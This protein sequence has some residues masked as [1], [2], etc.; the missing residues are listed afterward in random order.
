MYLYLYI[1]TT[2]QVIFEEL[3]APSANKAWLLGDVTRVRQ[4]LTI[5]CDNAIKF[6]RD[7]VSY[8]S[9]PKA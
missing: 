6:S 3:W 7:D 9:L 1:F 8:A 5:L 2:N 4:I